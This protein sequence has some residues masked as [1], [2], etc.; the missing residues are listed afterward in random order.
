MLS[1]KVNIEVKIAPS[2]VQYCERIIIR[3]LD[4]FE[5]LPKIVCVYTIFRL[6]TDIRYDMFNSSK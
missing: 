1:N 6:E 2:S 4:L 3:P 5:K